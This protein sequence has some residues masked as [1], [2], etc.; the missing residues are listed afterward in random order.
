M[1]SFQHWQEDFCSVPANAE[2]SEACVLVNQGVKQQGIASM[3]LLQSTKNSVQQ[4][5]KV[6]WGSENTLRKS[7]VASMLQ[8]WI[9]QS[10]K[11]SC[12]PGVC[13]G[14]IE[15]EQQQQNKRSRGQSGC[16]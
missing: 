7:P 9:C 12:D 4:H 13:L 10:S 6:E 14:L 11:G 8:K 1:Q 2:P 3:C 5:G 16:C 15:K